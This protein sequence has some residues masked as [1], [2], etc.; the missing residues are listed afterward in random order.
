MGGNKKN[1]GNAPGNVISQN[2]PA[3]QRPV[4]PGIQ[5]KGFAN[6]LMAKENKNP[7]VQPSSSGVA[8]AAST[9][10][11]RVGR[12]SVLYV[13]NPAGVKTVYKP[14][15]TNKNGPLETSNSTPRGS[16]AVKG[17]VSTEAQT[18]KSGREISSVC[19][20]A[21]HRAAVDPQTLLRMRSTSPS[22]SGSE[23]NTQSSVASKSMGGSMDNVTGTD[24]TPS[25]KNT[26]KKRK[27]RRANKKNKSPAGDQQSEVDGDD[28]SSSE[29]DSS[30]VPE[31]PVL[32]EVPVSKRPMTAVA[33]KDRPA[34]DIRIVGIDVKG[35]SSKCSS[36]SSIGSS[37][38][39]NTGPYQ[40]E[41]VVPSPAKDDASSLAKVAT[42]S[43]VKVIISKV[44]KNVIPLQAKDVAPYTAKAIVS[45]P[46]KAVVSP[47]NKVAASSPAKAVVPPLAKDAST[48]QVNDAASAPT[49]DEGLHHLQ[50]DRAKVAKSTAPNNEPDGKYSNSSDNREV[51]EALTALGSGQ[52]P[53]VT[54][55][56]AKK[57]RPRPSK[58]EKLLKQQKAAEKVADSMLQQ[59]TLEGGSEPSGSKD[60]ISE[61]LTISK[62]DTPSDDELTVEKVA[63]IFGSHI[64]PE[65]AK[66]EDIKALMLKQIQIISGKTQLLNKYAK[67]NGAV[68]KALEECNSTILTLEEDKTV[69]ETE[70]TLIRETMRM[71][72]GEMESKD[73]LLK[74]ADQDNL[75]LKEDL[76]ARSRLLEIM[77]KDRKG[78]TKS[79]ADMQKEITQVKQDVDRLSEENLGHLA[80]IERYEQERKVLLW[81]VHQNPAL[82][83]NI[84]L[85]NE[86][87][88]KKAEL[89]VANQNVEDLEREFTALKK[90]EKYVKGK[91]TSLSA[92]LGSKLEE[93]Q[94]E[95][96]P[97]RDQRGVD[98]NPFAA[99][100]PPVKKH[101]LFQFG[102]PTTF[103]SGIATPEIKF[104]MPKAFLPE[105][106][107]ISRGF[108]PSSY[109]S[110]GTQ[111]HI[112]PNG[113]SSTN[114]SKADMSEVSTQADSEFEVRSFTQQSSGGVM[115][116][117]TETEVDAGTQKVEMLEACTQTEAEVG[118]QKS[119]MM[120]ALS[121]TTTDLSI[122]SS[123]RAS[124]VAVFE[125]SVQTEVLVDVRK[126]EMLEASTRTEVEAS[127][128]KLEMVEAFTQ[129]KTVFGISSSTQ[130]I[131]AGVF[132]ASMQTKTEVD[133][134]EVKTL[135]ISAQTQAGI[136]GVT[137]ASVQTEHVNISRRSG[138]RRGIIIVIMMIAWAVMTLWSHK[139]E[140]QIWLD[141]N[142][143]SR[144][145]L[146]GIRD[147][148]MGPYGWLE[149]L[150]FDF[151]VWLQA[152]RVLPG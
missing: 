15:I 81:Q 89:A 36:L 114:K 25:G 30:I 45:S 62:T 22:K 66:L 76:D 75:R 61:C 56:A 138:V 71:C 10:T 74:S 52:G 149:R 86:L 130:T 35:Q 116:A 148:T 77:S 117:F 9:A 129:T 13:P 121:Q 37:A 60:G 119:E 112:E 83:E 92:E 141:A 14:I 73:A 127:T 2:T 17:S 104:Q 33:T 21:C 48:S 126:V 95:W 67:E 18:I 11:H 128:Q 20:K 124:S 49:K 34:P 142:D 100:S 63:D 133:A 26:K 32:S 111:M 70:I 150:E 24:T 19:V 16:N 1:T 46:A 4:S 103:A 5:I 122:S 140:E 99:M 91:R 27:T 42:P 135:E 39:K 84:R 8:A 53:S 115:E 6:T 29:S 31:Q 7:N 98:R 134:H 40:A 108:G 87:L 120:E 85:G 54:T 94:E 90:A 131:S 12:S 55:P 93:D 145:A 132:E 41:A 51:E 152:D 50:A 136:T 137:D 144:F 139:E 110:A 143:L 106:R 125:A 38:A 82:A 80:K 113:S 101:S 72:R 147:G 69:L 97:C 88:E 78:V 23:K 57:R 105:L 47:S 65:L 96:Q 43:P 123:T 146:I 58:A 118:I 44:A 3:Q 68:R 109:L 79:V 151:K 28:E 102:E 59:N 107:D 64:V